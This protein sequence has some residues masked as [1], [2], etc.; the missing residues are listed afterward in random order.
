MTPGDATRH[1]AMAVA[2]M[3]R[4]CLHVNHV[5]SR[6][7]RALVP[8]SAAKSSTSELLTAQVFDQQ[9]P[10]YDTVAEAKKYGIF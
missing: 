3:K 9:L 10:G 4:V 7:I 8:V 2:V 1:G 5:G 6:P